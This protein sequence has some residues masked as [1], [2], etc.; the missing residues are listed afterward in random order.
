MTTIFISSVQKELAAERAAI[1]D[2]LATDPLLRR[3]FRAFL[4]EDLPAKDRR[5]DALY[6]GELDRAD[7]YVAILGHDYGFEEA[8]GL[9]PTER[10]FNRATERGIPRIIFVKGVDDPAR[11]PKMRALIA[12]ASGQLVRRR[13]SDIPSLKEALYASLYRVFKGNLFDQ[14]DRTTDLVLSVIRQGIGTREHSTRAPAPYEIPRDVVREAVVNAIVHRDYTANAA[15]QVSVF[16]DR[17]EVWNPGHLLPP[18]T[19]ESLRGP[20]PSVLRNPRIAEA[21]FLARYI[22]KYG[23]GTLMMIRESREHA[24]PEPGFQ[25]Q[26]AEFATTVWRDWL[27]DE[28]MARLGLNERQRKGVGH[29]RK[30]GQISSGEYQELTGAEPRTATRDLTELIEKGVLVRHGQKRGARYTIG[31]QSDT[32]ATF[33]T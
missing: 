24:L 28:V 16:A 14:V 15:V 30:R 2:Y 3:H 12:K 33:R 19:P 26:A 20:H 1:R 8:D 18:L 17:F 11:H 32:N 25:Q 4:F 10:E 6:L 7:I 13:F 21:L 5:A 22:E 9:S 27:T 31:S 23:T 29:V